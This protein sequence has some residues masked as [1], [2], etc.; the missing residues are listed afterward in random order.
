MA[1]AI[2]S[3]ADAIAQG[4]KY[5]FNGQPCPQGHIAERSVRTCQCYVCKTGKPRKT[6]AERAANRAA[7]RERDRLAS[8]AYN[9]TNRDALN[10]KTRQKRAAR[11]EEE[12]EKAKAYYREWYLENR[13]RLIEKA[14]EWEKAHPEYVAVKKRN[15]RAREKEAEGRHTPQDIQRIHKAQRGK[16]AYCK[17][18]VGDD[19]HVDHIVALAR[20]GTNW[21]RN[22]QILCQPCNNQKHA[23]D[24]IKH[25]QSKGYLL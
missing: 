3:R 7:A 11:T 9:A 25:M 8:A 20:G 13:A 4:L 16:C 5:Y 6:E 21:P 23:R 14:M 18:K 1:D 10:E 12:R 22:L 17:C 19:Y 15:R 2:I 24:P